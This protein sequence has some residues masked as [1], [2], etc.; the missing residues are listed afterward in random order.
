MGC[1][2]ND[3]VEGTWHI[4]GTSKFL[5]TGVRSVNPSFFNRRICSSIALVIIDAKETGKYHSIVARAPS[6]EIIGATH[7]YNSSPYAGLYESG[8]GL[9]LKEYRNS[10][11]FGALLSHVL[12]EF[13]FRTPHMEEIFGESVCN[14]AFSQK[15]IAPFRTVETAIE[16][17]LMPAEAYVQEKSAHGRVATLDNFRCYVPKPHRIFIP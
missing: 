6:G 12:N 15:V 17:A 9:M 5:F 1:G 11:V 13:A 3:N 2:A 8:V 4:Q 7:L 16:V 10:G 14:H